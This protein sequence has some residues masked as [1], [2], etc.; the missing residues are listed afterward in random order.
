MILGTL[1]AVIALTVQAQI[2]FRPLSLS[3][4]LKAAQAEQKLVFIDC[5]TEW[6]GPCKHMANV[7]FV[8]PEAGEYF[9]PK[10]VSIKIDMEKGEGPDVGKQYSVGAYPTF[11][12]LNADGTLRGRCVGSAS[13]DEFIKRVD[14]AINEEKGLAWHQQQYSEG[15]RDRQFLLDYI[16][17]L[18]L[19]YMHDDIKGAVSEL[20]KGKSASEIIA[21]SIL[22]EAFASGGFNPYDDIFL[23]VY[24]QRDEVAEKLGI[25]R[26]RSL[27]ETWKTYGL[28]SLK[29]EGREYQGFDQE[30]FDA[31]MKLVADNNVPD[32]ESIRKFVLYNKASYS[33]DYP[34]LWTMVQQDLNQKDDEVNDNNV[35][36]DLSTLATEYKDKKAQ[37][38]LKKFAQRRIAYLQKKDTTGEREFTFEGKK[39]TMTGYVINQYEKVLESL[40]SK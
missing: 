35:L 5:Y 19:N 25:R 29:F 8:K 26:V 39:M 36:R 24:K 4:A 40:N 31:Y 30:K 38:T 17:L 3:E 1:C 7:E 27:D 21:D 12:L 18:K 9:N 23:E 6:C 13:I 2:E 15:K 14:N 10:F 16:D 33:K 32:P 28:Y 22:Y 11:L 37:K 20:L 34:T